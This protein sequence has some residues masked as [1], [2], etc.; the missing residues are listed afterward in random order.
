MNDAA[1]SEFKKKI[2]ILQIYIRSTTLNKM[3]KVSFKM[4]LHILM[5]EYATQIQAVQCTHQKERTVKVNQIKRVI[6]IFCRP[7]RMRI[8]NC[9]IIYVSGGD[10]ETPQH[11]NVS[12]KRT[13]KTNL[14]S[15][16]LI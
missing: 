15:S 3:D 12:K 14:M 2:K 9:F 7:S 8:T 1:Y 10:M 5:E 4:S 16:S 6:K 13:H 11:E